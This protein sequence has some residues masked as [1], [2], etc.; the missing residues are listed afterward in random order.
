MTR[1]I[2]KQPFPSGLFVV[3][4]QQGVGK[5]SFCAGLLRADYKRW[6]KWRCQEGKRLAS[7]YYQD[8]GI[9]LTI[10]DRLYI[11]G[12]KVVFYPNKEGKDLVKFLFKNAGEEVPD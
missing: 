11:E 6:A 1:E 4:G 12:E 9:E 3:R 10:S 5:T 2:R 8:N 7:E